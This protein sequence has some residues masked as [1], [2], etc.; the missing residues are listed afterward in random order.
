METTNNDT[1]KLGNPALL[2]LANSPE[3]KGLLTTSIGNT[4]NQAKRTVK[5]M[6]Y[7]LGFLAVTVV[8]YM[9]YK[10]YKNR[11]ISKGNNNNYPPA[12]ITEGQAESK[13][14]AL[15]EAMYG[16]GLNFPAVL[17]ALAG[18]NYN[19]YVLVF[20]KFGKQ[21]D[22]WGTELNLTEWLTNQLS[23]S[24]RKQLDVVIKGIL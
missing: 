8:G 14:D 2:T 23:E 10:A 16:A 19:G 24:Q 18:L 5:V 20:N 9:G 21:K 7:V 12:N 17:N 15:Y 3:G 11:F 13:A 1:E 4:V 6:P 22:F